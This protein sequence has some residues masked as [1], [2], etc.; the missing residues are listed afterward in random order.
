MK[1]LKQNIRI[2]SN[3]VKIS[4]CECDCGNKFE[5]QNS[6]IKTQKFCIKCQKN[7]S[8]KHNMSKSKFYRTWS[9]MKTRGMNRYKTGVKAVG[10]SEDWKSFQKFYDEMYKSYKKNVLKNGERNTTI[11]RIDN[12]KGYSKENCRW[13]TQKEQSRNK[14]NSKI[15]KG[16]TIMEWCEKYKIPYQRVYQRLLRGWSFEKTFNINK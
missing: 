15:I 2:T 11:D 9:D 4:L 1:I 10:I 8:I 14:T 12:S 16:K 6:K 5:I 3:Y 13:A 7:S